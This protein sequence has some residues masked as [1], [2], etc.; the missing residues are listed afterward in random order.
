MLTTAAAIAAVGQ[1]VDTGRAAKVEPGLTGA[2]A[3]HAAEPGPTRIAAHTAMARIREQI[4]T[5]PGARRL[6]G[7]APPGPRSRGG[8]LWLLRVSRAAGTTCHRDQ[9]Q[10]KQR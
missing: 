1:Q 5:P 9:Q 7:Q 4:D 8:Q 3:P 6:P 10:K 2:F